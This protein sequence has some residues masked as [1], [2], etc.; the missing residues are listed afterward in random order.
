LN[1][2]GDASGDTIFIYYCDHGATDMAA[3]P[4]PGQRTLGHYLA[5]TNGRPLFRSTLRRG[6]ARRR[7]RLTIL[8]TECCSNVVP[9]APAAGPPAL[10]P[11]LARSLFLRTRGIVDFTA[12]TFDPQNGTE[13]SAWTHSIGGIFTFSLGSTL[14]GAGLA[15]LDTSPRDGLVTWTEVFPRV[16]QATSEAFQEL[17]RA[18]LMN[19]DQLEPRIV[20][21]L[22]NQDQQRPWAFALDGR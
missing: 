14:I 19:P 2:Q 3:D 15:D 9:L 18:A 22:R 6:L 21:A 11:G 17:R 16:R 13:E 5:L 12:A 7:P 10:E 1:N 8:I 4:N 20:T